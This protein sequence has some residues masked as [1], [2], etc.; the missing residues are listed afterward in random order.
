[1][2]YEVACSAVPYD[3]SK[4]A[5]ERLLFPDIDRDTPLSDSDQIRNA[6]RYLH[7]RLLGEEDVS[8]EELAA[9]MAVLVESYDLGRAGL[10]DES[11]PTELAQPCRLFDDRITG[12]SLP[13]ERRINGDPE[14]TIRAWMAAVS[15]LLSDYRYLYE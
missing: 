9:T 10:A 1:M 8:D 13:Q 3:F 12:D 2:A 7:Q 15:Y 5:Q 4:P 14:Y 11:V 6:L